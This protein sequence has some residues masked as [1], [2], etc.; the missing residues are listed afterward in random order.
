MNTPS[1]SSET[2]HIALNIFADPGNS[3]I[4]LSRDHVDMLSERLNTTPVHILLKA[5]AGGEEGDARLGDARMRP[6]NAY[7]DESSGQYDRVA[8]M[9]HEADLPISFKTMHS[10]VSPVRSFL[11]F[12]PDSFLLGMEGRRIN[13]EGHEESFVIEKVSEVAEVEVIGPNNNVE[14]RPVRGFALEVTH[15]GLPAAISCENQGFLVSLQPLT[16]E[17]SPTW[18]AVH[19]ENQNS[20]IQQPERPM[21]DPDTDN[22]MEP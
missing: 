16:P 2:P 11:P 18:I 4:E 9:C 22:S 21:D 7:F 8:E 1:Q 3:W 17:A 19:E 10:P 13:V 6:A 14:M 12:E 5:W 20:N 15:R